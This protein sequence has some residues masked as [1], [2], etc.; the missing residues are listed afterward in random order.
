VAAPKGT[1]REIISYLEK[2]FKEVADDAE[3]QKIMKNLGQPVL[4]QTAAEYTVW[5]KQAYDQYGQLMK[6]MGA[7]GEVRRGHGRGRNVRSPVRK[8]AVGPPRVGWPDCVSDSRNAH[9]AQ[10]R[11]RKVSQARVLVV[12]LLTMIFV[13]QTVTYLPNL[14]FK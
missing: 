9:R 3:F 11:R 2:K 12:A 5:F 14:L 13:P 6:S 8:G 7:R 10:S 1:P 4:Y